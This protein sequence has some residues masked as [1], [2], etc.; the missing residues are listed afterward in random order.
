MPQITAL[1]IS[2]WFHPGDGEQ[3]RTALC[4]FCFSFS[5]ALCA[6]LALTDPC[7]LLMFRDAEIMRQ[8]QQAALGQQPP[9]AGNA[10]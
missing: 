8:K 10:K 4:A 9:Q 7:L 1:F 3:E 6:V 5:V 2:T